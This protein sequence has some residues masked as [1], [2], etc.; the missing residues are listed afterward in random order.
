MSARYYASLDPKTGLLSDM[1]V[2]DGTQDSLAHCVP[3]TAMPTGSLGTKYTY[4][5]V[6]QTAV[7][8]VVPARVQRP[9]AA[10][11][12]DVQGLPAAERNKLLAAVCAAFLQQNPAFARELGIAIDGDAPVS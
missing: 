11:L 8:V 3:L 12:A 10:I 7:A 4:D 2:Y 1:R 9:L 5:A 6:E